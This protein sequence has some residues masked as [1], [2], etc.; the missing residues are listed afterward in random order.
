MPT[1]TPSSFSDNLETVEI[2]G[3]TS[4]AGASVQ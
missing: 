4:A 2:A 3:Q 1:S